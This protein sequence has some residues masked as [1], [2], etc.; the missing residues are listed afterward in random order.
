M[1]VCS[2]GMGSGGTVRGGTTCFFMFFMNLHV[3]DSIS[4]SVVVTGITNPI[5]IGIFLARVWHSETVV[6]EK[7]R[8]P[9]S[10]GVAVSYLTAARKRS[11]S[12]K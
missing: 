11:R 10:P 3:E 9:L 12:G 8:I 5:A 7:K 6:L 4:I 2:W 1:C